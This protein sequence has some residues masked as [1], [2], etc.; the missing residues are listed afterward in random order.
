MLW[1]SLA[2]DLVGRFLNIPSI[3]SSRK[4]SSARKIRRRA[5]FGSSYKKN[6]NISAAQFHSPNLS[7]SISHLLSTFRFAEI[8]IAFGCLLLLLSEVESFQAF[9]KADTLHLSTY[10]STSLPVLGRIWTFINMPVLKN[11]ATGFDPRRRHGSMGTPPLVA[12]AQ[13]I[14]GL[15]E[16][17]TEEVLRGVTEFLKEIDDG[18]AKENSILSQIPSYVTGVPKGDEK[19]CNATA[20][21]KH[22]HWIEINCVL[23]IG[24]LPSC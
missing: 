14:A 22:F 20:F 8:F 3:I 1:A 9:V 19:V 21:W 15:F 13:E 24:A 2:S 7:T 5:A 11:D 18:L 23:S 17:P 6:E 16:Y 10:L 4:N 12:K